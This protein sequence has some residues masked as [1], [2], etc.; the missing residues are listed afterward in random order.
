MNLNLSLN[1]K[2]PCISLKAHE[3]NEDGSEM[4]PVIQVRNAAQKGKL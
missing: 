2:I 3:I 4:V 1:R